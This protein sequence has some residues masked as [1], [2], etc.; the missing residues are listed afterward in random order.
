[1]ISIRRAVHVY[2]A[3]KPVPRGM[4]SK[5]LKRQT[6]KEVKFQLEEVAKEIKARNVSDDDCGDPNPE[7]PP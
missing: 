7:K 6:K 3:R 4:P 1:M 5:L 2:D